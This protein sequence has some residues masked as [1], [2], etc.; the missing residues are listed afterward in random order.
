MTGSGEL[1]CAA[2]HALATVAGLERAGE[3]RDREAA[4]L[5]PAAEQQL[6]EQVFGVVAQGVGGVGSGRSP[7]ECCAWLLDQPFGEV[8]VATYR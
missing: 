6:R 7:A 1:R 8:R 2:L 5:S 3:L 4:L